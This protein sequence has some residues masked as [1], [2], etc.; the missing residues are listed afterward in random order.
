MAIAYRIL[1]DVDLAEDAVQGAIVTAWRQL[2]ALRD[3]DKFESWLHQLLVHACSSEA[4]RSRRHRA[5][6]LQV[7]PDD[8]VVTRDETLTV[9]HRDQLDR[10]FRRLPPEQRA[11]LV[12]HHYLGLTQSEVAERLA[13]PEGTVKSRIHYASAALRAV[14]EADAR[15]VEKPRE[16]S[17]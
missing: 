1:R 11:V 14:L 3:P 7:W 12:L 2:R 15:T 16:R 9:Q 4:R 17:A 6:V 5:D 10:G 13:I 8:S